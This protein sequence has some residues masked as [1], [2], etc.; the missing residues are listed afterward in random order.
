MD[1]PKI[2]D[3]EAMSDVDFTH[4]VDDLCQNEHWPHR[5]LGM[6]ITP[7]D[8]VRAVSMGHKMWT[9]WHVNGRWVGNIDRFTT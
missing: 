6:D 1:E 7:K 9:A 3:V 5:N 2:A 8:R 4:F